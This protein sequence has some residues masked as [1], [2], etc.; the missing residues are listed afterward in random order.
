MPDKFIPVAESSGLMISIGE[1]VFRTA[2][3]QIR[4]WQDEGV[5]VV[6]VAVNVS[7][8]Q[9][10]QKGFCELIKQVLL[11]TGI[12]PHCIVSFRQACVTPS[13]SRC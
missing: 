1:W 5:L 13:E 6:P 3:S 11:E 2:C 10:R 12:A 4:K 7:A 8:V 9:F